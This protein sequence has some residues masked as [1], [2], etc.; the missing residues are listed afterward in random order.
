MDVSFFIKVWGIKPLRANTLGSLGEECFYCGGMFY[1]AGW[2]FMIGPKG[3][4]RGTVFACRRCV[5]TRD[6][7]QLV[8]TSRHHQVLRDFWNMTLRS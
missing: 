7:I 5:P 3:N 1:H 2:G 4:P 8:V 6:V